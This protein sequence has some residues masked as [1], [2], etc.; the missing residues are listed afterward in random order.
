MKF[1]HGTN[2][3]STVLK[4]IDQCHFNTDREF[5]ALSGAF[6]TKYKN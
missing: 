2:E 5:G 3:E 6:F 4:F 1:L